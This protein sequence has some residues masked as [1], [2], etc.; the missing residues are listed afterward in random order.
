MLGLGPVR[1]LFAKPPQMAVQQIRI[2]GVLKER[3][4]LRNGFQLFIPVD[5][6]V[7]DAAR[8]MPQPLAHLAK[9]GGQIPPVPAQQI[10]DR[11]Y[12]RRLKRRLGRR[13][14]TPDDPDRPRLQEIPGFTPPDDRKATRLVQIRSDLGQEF[15]VR[16]P[17][18]RRK[19]QLGLHAQ[20]KARQHPHRRCPVQPRRARKIQKRLV[21]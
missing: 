6:A 18:R 7:I 21:Q 15:V 3:G 13:A 17:D 12:A 5:P 14:D 4:F 8:Q 16:Q 9:A 11:A 20:Q 10:A 19:A 2:G 1:H